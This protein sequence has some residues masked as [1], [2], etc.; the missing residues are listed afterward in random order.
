M[1]INNFDGIEIDGRNVKNI[2]DA[3]KLF[4][5]LGLRSFRSRQIG[6]FDGDGNLILDAR[7]WYPLSP[8]L[9]AFHEIAE[10]VGASKMFE[11]G[12]SVP[13]NSPF[14][15]GID[16]IHSAMESVNVAYHLNHR[17]DGRVMFDLAR[18]TF[19]DGIG[20]Y[21]CRPRPNGR[22]IV[23]ECE[24][25]YPCDMDRGL[26]TTLA[27]RFRPNAVFEHLHENVCRKKGHSR[28]TYAVR[29]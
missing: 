18:G 2:V 1:E 3:F 26:L 28:C 4:P 7:G 19:E 16:D 25:P 8:W 21:A 24:N 22:E 15:P 17:K 5:E 27:R 12:K 6:R 23:M 11:I 10:Q 20:H 14:P 9:E 13:K 29:W